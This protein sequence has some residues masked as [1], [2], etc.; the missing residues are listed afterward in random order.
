[1]ERVNNMASPKFLD[2]E[3]VCQIRKL[4]ATDEY[5][6]E[7]LAERF[8]VS[9]STICKIVN[10]YIHKKQVDVAMTGEANVKMGYKYG[11]KG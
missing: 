5:T 4:Y 2:G 10:H 9:Q 8:E 6:Q 11:D 1:V 7:Q 3:I